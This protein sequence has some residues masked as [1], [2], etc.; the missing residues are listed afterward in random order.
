MKS[1]APCI[2]TL[3]SVQYRAKVALEEK[4]DGSWAVISIHQCDC[5]RLLADAVQREHVRFIQLEWVDPLLFDL[6]TKRDVHSH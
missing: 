4:H 2:E 6:S 5:Q 3:T 1:T